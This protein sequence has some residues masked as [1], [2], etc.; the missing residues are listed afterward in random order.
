MGRIELPNVCQKGGRVYYRYKVGQKDYY[1]RL[2]PLDSPNFATAYER[3]QGKVERETPQ[4]GTIS[5][6][7][8]EY[9]ASAEFKSIRSPITRA[10]Y[11]R[12]L[13]MLVED[14]G[15]KLARD[16]AR[17]DV[18]RERDRMAETPGKANNWVARLHTLMEFAVDRGYRQTNPAHKIKALPIGEHEPWPADVLHKALERATPITR[19]AIVLGLCTGARIGDAIKLRHKW[20]DGRVLQFKTGKNRT[21]VA[22]PLHPL[23]LGEIA[24]HPRKAE[25]ILYDR[26][27]RAFKS[28][29]ALQERI[30]DLMKRIGAPGYTFHGL[31]KNAACYLHELGLSDTEIGTI[32]AMTPQTVRHYTKR[33]RALMVAKNVAERIVKGDVMQKSGGRELVS[34]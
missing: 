25:T 13:D 21:D 29:G 3:M 4:A 34:A 20:H 5:A 28:T 30:R 1:H 7:V 33:S 12:Y 18:K 9:R 11:N 8:A 24:L 26:T 23:L 14:H 2:P 17:Q 16:M 10:N 22:V 19:L 6:L 32:L 31:R 27:G 15:K